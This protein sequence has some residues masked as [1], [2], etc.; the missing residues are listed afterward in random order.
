MAYGVVA[1]IG[2]QTGSSPPP[3]I[4]K[5]N[6]EAEFESLPRYIPKCF[7]RYLL[8]A[9]I[10]P[11]SIAI[12]PITIDH[13]SVFTHHSNKLAEALLAHAETGRRA[14]AKNFYPAKH[15]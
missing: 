13:S 9:L 2:T 15:S 12:H 14:H 5:K 6:T 10:E 7:R 8:K 3:F 11:P 4:H 1:G